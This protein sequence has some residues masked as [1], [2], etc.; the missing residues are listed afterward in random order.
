MNRENISSETK[1][2]TVDD[3]IK[4]WN[5]SVTPKTLSNWRSMKMGPTFTKIMGKPLYP[6]DAVV[7][8]ER[9]LI[10][11]KKQPDVFSSR[12]FKIALH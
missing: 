8:Y 11:I 7:E 5:G 4:R 3:I 10:Q 9:E 2:L 6:I 1:Y 12:L